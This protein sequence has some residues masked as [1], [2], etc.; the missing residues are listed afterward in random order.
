[1]EPQCAGSVRTVTAPAGTMSGATAETLV[2][3][4]LGGGHHVI[5]SVPVV[6]TYLAHGDIVSCS[7][8]DGTLV[9]D[10]VVVRGGGTTLRLLVD[11][12]HA[13]HRPGL[14]E[15]L[16]GQLIVSGCVVEWIGN[17]V[18][19]VGVGPD[20][21]AGDIGTLCD[22]WEDAG[23]VKVL[24]CGRGLSGGSAQQSEN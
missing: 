4:N 18:L 19:A 15:Q 6:A 20:V 1:M 14:R 7:E 10:D 23:V 22:A 2:T 11:S 13:G 3:W 9:V 17:H 24:P 5:R 21:D 12:E 16:A 8:R